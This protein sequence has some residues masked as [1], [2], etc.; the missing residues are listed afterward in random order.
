MLIS[1]TGRLKQVINAKAPGPDGLSI[2][3][4]LKQRLGSIIDTI[5][6][7]AKVCDSYQKRPTAGMYISP[8][9]YVCTSTHA[10]MAVKFFTSTKWQGKFTEVAQQFADHKTG[11][12]FDLQIHA[13][14]GITTAN[15]TLTAMNT[16]FTELSENVTKLMEVVFERM[17]T[18]EEREVSAIVSKEPGGID[19][20]LKND[21]LLEKVLAKQKTNK[22]KDKD[23]DVTKKRATPGQALDAVLTVTEL[24]KEVSKDVEQVLADNKFFDQK[25]EAMKMQVEEVKVEIRHESDRVID[26]ILAGPHERIVDRVCDLH[27]VGIIAVADEHNRTYTTSGRKW[28]VYHTLLCG[29]EMSLIS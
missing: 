25:F 20:V 10:R 14:V 15:V 7:C 3:D 21:K 11:I 28:C 4:R 24:R 26:T 2:E 18:P 22:G 1:L 12:Q 27:R 23:D 6:R 9:P 5:K 16:S 29:H 19:A 13:S 8:S 17:R